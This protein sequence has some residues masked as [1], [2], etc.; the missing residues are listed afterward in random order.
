MIPQP[1]RYTS[2]L[3]RRREAELR[4]KVDPVKWAAYGQQLEQAAFDAGDWMEDS[5]KVADLAHLDALTRCRC[6]V[7]VLGG[8]PLLEVK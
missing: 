2:S 8:E 3:D 6:M 5:V 7:R 4:L 1:S